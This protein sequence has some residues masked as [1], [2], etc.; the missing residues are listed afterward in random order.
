MLHPRPS[1]RRSTPG[2]SPSP[3][4]S[5]RSW[6]WWTRRW[7]TSPCA[8]LPAACRRRSSTASGSSPATWPPTPSSCR[9]RGWLSAH[10]GRRNYFLLSIAVFTLASGLC[11]MAA[12]LPQLILFRVL[13]GLAG[14]GLQPSSQGVLLDSFPPE[15]QGAAMTMFGVAALLG[16]DRRPDA[17]RLARRYLRLALDL[18]HQPPRGAVGFLACY[19]LLDDPAYLKEERARS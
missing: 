8:T 17:G 10:F 2:S 4:S 5:R 18:L 13:Q 19:A 11:G 7:R 6:K 15:K 14:G 9:S 3:W 1:A 12:S 16:P